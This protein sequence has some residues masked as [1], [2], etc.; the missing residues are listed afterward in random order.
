[1]KS[2]DESNE[3]FR[4]VLYL[5]ANFAPVPNVEGDEGSLLVTQFSY[6]HESSIFRLEHVMERNT[7]LY[8]KELLLHFHNFRSMGEEN[9]ATVIPVQDIVSVQQVEINLLGP[10]ERL[11][12]QLAFQEVSYG[13]YSCTDANMY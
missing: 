7:D 3:H 12:I 5:R 2:S 11:N 1:M 4:Y 9:D 8:D 10:R 13:I 6:L